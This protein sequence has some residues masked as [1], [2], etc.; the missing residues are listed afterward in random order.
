MLISSSLSPSLLFLLLSAS[1]SAFI[2][3]PKSPRSFIK[4]GSATWF[5]PDGVNDC[6][7]TFATHEAVVS[8]PETYF[9]NL[10]DKSPWCNTVVCLRN[11]D[12][13]KKS[14]TARVLDSFNGTNDNLDITLGA[15]RALT[16]D[17]GVD[18]GILSRLSWTLGK[19]PDSPWRP[20]GKPQNAILHP[21]HPIHRPTL[22]VSPQ[23]P[24]VPIILP[25]R[26][27]IKS[28]KKIVTVKVVRKVKSTGKGLARGKTMGVVRLSPSI[29]TSTKPKSINVAT[30]K[31]KTVTTAA[32]AKSIIATAKAKPI[33]ASKIKSTIKTKTP[34]AK[35]KI[36][37]KSKNR[38]GDKSKS[39][40]RRN[41]KDR[42]SRHG[43]SHDHRGHR[44]HRGHHGR[45][46]S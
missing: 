17:K 13:P 8:I 38:K 40:H 27:P 14:V 39:K 42:S 44:G 26:S 18:D 22:P 36:K 32:H 33:A 15:F 12:S 34:D 20:F 24:V 9:N 31:E 1:T 29:S 28:I 25:N 10:G 37:I 41:D 16:N 19:C 30:T 7:A 23:R 3:T 5:I 4:T 45:H 46:S 2:R 43:H 6:S 21:P 11:L 35:I